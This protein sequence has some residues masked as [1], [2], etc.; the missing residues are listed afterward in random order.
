MSV[1]DTIA[2]CLI[3]ALG[4]ILALHFA[5]FWL[6]GGVFIHESNKIILTVETVMSAAI[7]VFGVERLAS[8]ANPGRQRPVSRSATT[9]H[10][11]SVVRGTASPASL[12]YCQ[13][14]TPGCTAATEIAGT[15]G[16]LLSSTTSAE[17]NT[18]E[19]VRHSAESD[20]GVLVRL[21]PM[22]HEPTM[23]TGMVSPTTPQR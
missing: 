1:K 18:T 13:A 19:A 4:A 10:R 9:M 21:T 3:I 8:S 2:S 6:Y 7:L 11:A 14:H 12:K 22:E 16:L 5:L 20:S 23:D 15:A 17:G